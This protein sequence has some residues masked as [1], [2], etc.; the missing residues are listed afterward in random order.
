MISGSSLSELPISSIRRIGVAPPSQKEIIEEEIR[1]CEIP[2]EDPERP[3]DDRT[4][5]IE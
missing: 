2:E 4:R 5:E 1:T 3:I